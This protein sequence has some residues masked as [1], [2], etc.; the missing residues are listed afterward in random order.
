MFFNVKRLNE[1]KKKIC[2]HSVIFST[3]TNIYEVHHW[4]V[5]HSQLACT[6]VAAFFVT[7][8]TDR[9]S[10]RLSPAMRVHEAGYK[11]RWI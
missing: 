5:D 4:A 1:K 8:G 11:W 2:T 6:V 9:N 3:T 10:V 7:V